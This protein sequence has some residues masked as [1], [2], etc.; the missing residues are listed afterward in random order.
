MR[1]RECVRE[2]ERERREAREKK[3]I[4]SL[5]PPVPVKDP[6]N[7]L[8]ARGGDVGEVRVLHSASPA[9]ECFWKREKK[10]RESERDK[11]RVE[12]GSKI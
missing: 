8:W 9:L 11:V 10:E 6:E 12:E 7:S 3:T 1:E 2:R 4:F 5:P